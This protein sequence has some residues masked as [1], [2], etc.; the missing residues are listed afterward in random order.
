MATVTVVTDSVVVVKAAP[1]DGSDHRLVGVAEPRGPVASWL[2]LRFELGNVREVLRA[3][4]R[5]LVAMREA[6][7]RIGTRVVPKVA[8]TRWG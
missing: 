5:T 1:R 3:T 6:R 7:S 4:R 2:P 8:V